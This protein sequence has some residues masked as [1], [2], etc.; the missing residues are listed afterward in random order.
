MVD[1]RWRIKHGGF[2]C[3]VAVVT[4]LRSRC[5]LWLKYKGSSDIMVY[6][7]QVC[8]KWARTIAHNGKEE[9]IAF[10]G[11]DTSCKRNKS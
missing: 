10:H 5:S 2:N 11:I 1:P 8:V 6:R 3:R 7:P 9:N 4:C